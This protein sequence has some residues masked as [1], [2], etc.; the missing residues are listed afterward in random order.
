MLVSALSLILSAG[1]E[2]GCH[3]F[4]QRH[5]AVVD[6]MLQRRLTI[7]DIATSL[8][9]LGLR[10]R[11]HTKHQHVSQTPHPIGQAGGH[12]GRLLLPLLD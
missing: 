11:G 2:L 3:R 1:L 7:I 4:P 12:R 5:M 8:T 9:C 10:P 6:T